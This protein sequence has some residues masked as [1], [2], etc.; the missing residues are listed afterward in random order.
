MMVSVDVTVLGQ[1]ATTRSGGLL[2]QRD[3]SGEVVEVDWR[4][5]LGYVRSQPTR[6][7]VFVDHDPGWEVGEVGYLERS[8]ANGLLALARVDDDIVEL[9]NDGTC[10]YLSGH[11]V[12]LSLAPGHYERALLREVSLVRHTAIRGTRPIAWSPHSGAPCSM[13]F[14]WDET[15]SAGVEALAERKDRS[16]QRL[17]I[18]D[19]DGLDL[20][21]EM[22]TDPASVWS[23]RNNH[24]AAASALA[25]GAAP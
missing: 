20:V 21:D 12:A 10:W 24:P 16:D 9:L 11:V 5:P 4:P 14:A 15:W 18:H 7:P 19:I 8:K 22:L 2:Q 13:P 25:L 17:V 23:G 1:L 3:L 6:I